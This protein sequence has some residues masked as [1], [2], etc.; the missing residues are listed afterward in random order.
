[1]DLFALFFIP[2]FCFT[3]RT[4]GVV[5]PVWG[6]S[7]SQ[8]TCS[9]VRDFIPDVHMLAPPL[10]FAPQLRSL[11]LESQL[12]PRIAPDSG[13]CSKPPY[14]FTFLQNHQRIIISTFIFLFLSAVE[15]LFF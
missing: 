15:I 13:Y 2:F 11:G 5:T 10:S 9:S 7:Q 3:L 8:V 6:L 14:I 12:F 4:Q 1:V